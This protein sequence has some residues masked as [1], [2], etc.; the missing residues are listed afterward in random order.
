MIVDYSMEYYQGILSQVMKWRAIPLNVL[1]EMSGYQGTK[2]S[3]YRAIRNLESRKLLKSTTFNGM[4]KI[5]TPTPELA[6]LTSK[7][8]IGFQEE[9]LNHEAIVTLLCCELL[10]WE[11]FDSASLPHEITGGAYDSG[12]RRLPDAIIE[13]K[14]VGRPFK[15]ALEV[16]V[17]RKS[18]TRVQ[19]KV[20]DYLKNDVFDF[21]F[22]VFNYR[23]TFEAYQRFIGETI[24]R[25]QFEQDQ[26]NHEARFIL[27]F[28]R[29][30]IGNKCKLDEIELFYLG[31]KTN[32]EF[33]FGKRRDG[34]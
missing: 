5:V 9:S 3:F 13:G 26:K 14:N 24:Q 31:K 32:L 4:S 27:G 21:I 34:R 16:E 30:L 12:I 7:K 6:S 28:T 29:R 19:N 15:M 25:P 17:T 11:I 23:P 2:T 10:T 18:K 22:Y 20:E 1:Q 8:F 33:V